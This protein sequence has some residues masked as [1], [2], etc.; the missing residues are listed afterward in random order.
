[1]AFKAILKRKNKMETIIIGLLLLTIISIYIIKIVFFD[2]E[3]NR[4]KRK[5]GRL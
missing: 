1:M 3:E 5:S 2:V 4:K